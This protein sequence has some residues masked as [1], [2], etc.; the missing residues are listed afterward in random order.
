MSF[1]KIDA[2]DVE[3]ALHDLG[4]ASGPTLFFAHATSFCAKMWQP[5]ADVLSANYRCVGV[6]LRG[7]GRSTYD[8]DD[9]S[10]QSIAKDLLPA[11]AHCKG[12]SD[13]PVIGIGHS[14]GGSA[15]VLAETFEP[16]LFEKI[17]AF[18]PILLSSEPIANH[19]RTQP[20]VEGALRR[21]TEFASREAA[22]ERY[23]NKFPLVFFDP[24][25]SKQY[26]EWGFEDQADG[27]IAL[28]CKPEHE[29]QI[30]R[31]ANSGIT[32]TIGSVEAPMLFAIGPDDGDR[33]PNV[34]EIAEQQKNVT[35]KEYNDLNHFG[36][37]QNPT[38]IA[39][40]I[41]EWLNS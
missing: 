31:E 6:D 13:Q 24:A 23:A 21:K 16:G 29:A 2:G 32:E 36:P 8:G 22:F 14:L 34:V 33:V 18:E 28:S 4:G 41:Q 9:M 15:L 25:C 37:L 3:L 39:S 12:S 11:I 38:R 30:Y 27:S 40:D 20:L 26:L 35:L 7:H 19:P 17:W 10:W 1:T 5:I